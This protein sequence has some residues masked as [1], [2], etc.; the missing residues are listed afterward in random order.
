MTDLIRFNPSSS[1]GLPQN[2][3]VSVYKDTLLTQD[4]WA[5]QIKRLKQAFPRL[6]VEWFDILTEEL[7]DMGF[8][9]QRLKDAVKNLIRTCQYPEPTVAQVLSYDRQVQTITYYEL[10]KLAE[11]D[12]EAWD[13]YIAVDAHGVCRFARKSEAEAYGLKPWV[14]EKHKEFMRTGKPLAIGMV[15]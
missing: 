8:T 14:P 4:V 9:N 11:I 2:I 15:I 13:S 3:G 12:R 10:K 1:Q 5:E 6:T 7:R